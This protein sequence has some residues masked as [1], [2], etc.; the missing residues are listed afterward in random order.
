[1]E[2]NWKVKTL[3][4]GGAIG[5]FTGLIAAYLFIQRAEIEERKPRLSAGEGV[6]MGVGV[7]GL[8][9]VI[10]DMASPRK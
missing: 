10:S 4:I 9:K 3:V 8:L 1:M 2:N 6:K 5:L 7:I